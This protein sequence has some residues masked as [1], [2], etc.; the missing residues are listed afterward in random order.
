MNA[1]Y[2]PGTRTVEIGEVG[3]LTDADLAKMTSDELTRFKIACEAA[4]H[5]I[6]GQLHEADLRRQRGEWVNFGWRKSAI[7]ARVM[8]EHQMRLVDAE[9]TRRRGGSKREG[10]Y[11]LVCELCEV[12]KEKMGDATFREWLNEAAAR[13][14]SR[15]ER[16]DEGAP[17]RVSHQVSTSR[18]AK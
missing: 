15:E 10:N 2:V 13:L 17:P 9:R 1:A 12:V 5:A 18:E 7:N 8:Y 6:K 3:D 4:L 16:D 11:K 14:R